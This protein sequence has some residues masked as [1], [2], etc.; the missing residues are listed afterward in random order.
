MSQTQMNTQVTAPQIT[1][2]QL[3]D[4]TLTAGQA[5]TGTVVAGQPLAN[6]A[7]QIPAGETASLVVVLILGFLLWRSVDQGKARWPIIGMAF[8]AGVLLSGSL[9]GQMADQLADSVGQ[10]AVQMFTT[11]ADTN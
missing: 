2:P 10:A 6:Q 11:V 9:I 3:A 4:S 1:V 5:H 8:T 7:Q